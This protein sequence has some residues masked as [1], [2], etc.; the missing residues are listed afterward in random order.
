MS[1]LTHTV[2]P[3]CGAELQIFRITGAAGA[4]EQTSDSTRNAN[5]KL[6]IG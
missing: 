6:R 3:G 5:P 2:P 4:N 1:A